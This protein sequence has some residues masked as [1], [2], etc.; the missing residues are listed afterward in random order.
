MPCT[1]QL[2]R[3]DCSSSALYERLGMIWSENYWATGLRVGGL[4][5]AKAISSSTACRRAIGPCIVGSLGTRM[6]L[7]LTR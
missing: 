4:G 7:D 6:S 2:A 3:G 5:D 1:T